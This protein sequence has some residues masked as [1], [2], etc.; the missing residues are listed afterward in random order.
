VVAAVRRALHD[1]DKD[2]TYA[3]ISAPR[4]TEPLVD[5]TDD[6]IEVPTRVLRAWSLDTRLCFAVCLC[7]FVD[8]IYIYVC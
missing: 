3:H 6:A 1:F 5:E 7:L 8:Q 2:V 4:D